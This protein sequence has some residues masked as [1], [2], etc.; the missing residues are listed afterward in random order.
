MSERKADSC[1][2]DGRYGAYQLLLR[3]K[4]RAQSK[5]QTIKL[6]QPAYINKILSKFYFDK[7]HLTTTSI[8]KFVLLQPHTDS[9][10]ITAKKKRYQGMTGS[11]M[12]SIVE[13]KPDITFAILV[14]ARFVKNLSHQYSKAVKIVLQY[15]EDS[16]EQRIT[17][18]GQDKLFLEGY[19]DSD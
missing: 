19:S 12:L 5:K 2:F 11:I 4:S 15:L 13:T 9:Q 7:A 18:D 6:S 17:F 14:I 1:I 8:K 16:K 10:A 3:A